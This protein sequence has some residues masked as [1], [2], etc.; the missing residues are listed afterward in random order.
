MN[1]FVVMVD[2]GREREAIVNPEH[3]RRDALDV[4]RERL[5]DGKEI[6]FVHHIHDGICE[7]V[8]ADIIAEAQVLMLEAAE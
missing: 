5:G 6:T 4:V 8:T 3:T 2:F 7:D 1:Y